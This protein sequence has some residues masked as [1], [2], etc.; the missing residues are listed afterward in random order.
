MNF[1]AKTVLMRMANEEDEKADLSFS[2]GK[3]VEKAS[4][5]LYQVMIIFK[6]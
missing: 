5:E 1:Y 3:W 6:K 2:C 4:G